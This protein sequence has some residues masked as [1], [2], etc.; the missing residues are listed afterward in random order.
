MVKMIRQL[1]MKIQMKRIANTFYKGVEEGCNNV[2][3]S[4]FCDDRISAEEFIHNL[5]SISEALITPFDS[6]Q[7]KHPPL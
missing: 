3:K 5:E 1:L 6:S 7:K 4:C 2:D